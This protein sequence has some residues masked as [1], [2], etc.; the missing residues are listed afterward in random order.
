MNALM[1]ALYHHRDSR[2]M[3]PWRAAAAQEPTMSITAA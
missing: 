1:A 3:K 2:K